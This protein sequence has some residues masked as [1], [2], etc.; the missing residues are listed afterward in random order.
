MHERFFRAN[1]DR[2]I[3]HNLYVV[4][5]FYERWVLDELVNLYDEN[6]NLFAGELLPN[7]KPLQY[8]PNDEMETFGC[9][10]LISQSFYNEEKDDDLPDIDAED[11]ADNFQRDEENAMVTQD[12]ELETYALRNGYEEAEEDDGDVDPPETSSGELDLD[13]IRKMMYKPMPQ[14]V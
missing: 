1:I 12:Y 4:P 3:D 9:D 7:H 11:D 5:Q 2:G 14:N 10:H 13:M 8:D 6:P